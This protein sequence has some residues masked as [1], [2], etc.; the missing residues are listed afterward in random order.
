MDTCGALKRFWI[1]KQCTKCLKILDYTN[2]Y[3]S[4]RSQKHFGSCKKCCREAFLDRVSTEEGKRK[5]QET[6]SSYGKSSKRK[7]SSDRHRFLKEKPVIEIPLKVLV[8]LDRAVW[9]RRYEKSVKGRLSNFKKYHKRAWRDFLGADLRMDFTVSDWENLM[10]RQENRCP[11]CNREFNVSPP[12]LQA[13]LDHIVSAAVGGGLTASN[14]Q[15]LCRSCNGRKAYGK[16]NEGCKEYILREMYIK[17]KYGT[18]RS[19]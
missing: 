8:N 15:I 18:K 19:V 17:E 5:R 2:F 6:L 7:L 4:E 16:T 11:I 12:G 9:R 3:F 14:I 1:M 10:Q 13:T